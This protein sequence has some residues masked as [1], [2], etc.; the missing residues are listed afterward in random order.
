MT[1]ETRAPIDLVTHLTEAAV[2]AIT[3]ERP[4]LEHGPVGL[5]DIMAGKAGGVSGTP[6]TAR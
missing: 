6:G 1:V 3:S 4:A 2:E 5:R